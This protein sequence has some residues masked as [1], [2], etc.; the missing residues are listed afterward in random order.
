MADIL[1]KQANLSE[2]PLRVLATLPSALPST[3]Y[4][5]LLCQ[6]TVDGKRAFLRLA[7]GTLV[8]L[9]TENVTIDATE[10]IDNTVT[11]NI[12]NVDDLPDPTLI[13]VGSV[14]YVVDSGGT[15]LWS[16]TASPGSLIKQEAIKAHRPSRTIT[17]D[18]TLAVT[19]VDTRLIVNSASAVIITL[20]ELNYPPDG[21]I[22]IFRRG[23]GSVT[24]A[25]S[26]ATSIERAGG[27]SI[28]TRYKGATLFF[29]GI[30][31]WGLIGD[32]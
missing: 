28:L 24:I 15:K 19:D 25:T 30:N 32:V 1:L 29:L 27:L 31:A 20:P 2:I 21:E 3:G 16:W 8:N 9:F 4:A 5:N 26:G 10:T 18:V 22:E 7:D 12:Y 14:A 6:D 17:G 23:A 13:P 11:N